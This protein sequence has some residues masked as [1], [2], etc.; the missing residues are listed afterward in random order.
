MLNQKLLMLLACVAFTFSSYTAELA[1]KDTDKDGKVSEAEF[2]GD[3]KKLKKKFKKLD[4]DEDGFLNAA[5]F[6]KSQKKKKKK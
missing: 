5:E 6:K 2:C 1:D 3:D 4:A